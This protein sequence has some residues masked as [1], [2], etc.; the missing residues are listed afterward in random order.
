MPELAPWEIESVPPIGSEAPPAYTPEMGALVEEEKPFDTE[1]IVEQVRPEAASPEDFRLPPEY[2]DLI[3]DR[4]VDAEAAH[5]APAVTEPAAAPAEETAHDWPFDEVPPAGGEPSAP[6]V[7]EAPPAWEGGVSE[8]RDSASHSWGTDEEA[9][10]PEAQQDVDLAGEEDEGVTVDEAPPAE[11]PKSGGDLNSFFFE[12][13][14]EKKGK[15]QKQD[16]DSFW[17]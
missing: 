7:T 12:D 1:G 15:E 17:E 13:D 9:L 2:Q 14:V 8:E 6:P 3:G 4:P 5:E 11:A 10:A 16:P